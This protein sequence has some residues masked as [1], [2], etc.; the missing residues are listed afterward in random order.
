[1]KKIFIVALI[2]KIIISLFLKYLSYT[3]DTDPLQEEVILKYFTEKE[4]QDGVEYSRSGF[5]ISLFSQFLDYAMLILLVF[6][7]FSQ[8][9]EKKITDTLSSGYY[10]PTLVFL[11]VIYFFGF[12]LELPFGYYYEMILEKEFGFS[13][14]TFESWINLNIKNFFLGLFSMLFSGWGII[15]LL[16]TF[17]RSWTFLV[18]IVSFILSLF[19]TILYPI[20]ITPLYY[21][22]EP[23]TK[24]SLKMKINEL[25]SKENI[26]V[27]DVYM[28]M[29]SEYS[30]HTNAYFTGWGNQK[31]IFLYDTLIEKHTEEEIISILGHEIGHWKYNHQWKGMLLMTVLLFIGCV[32]VKWIFN[33]SKREGS[34]GLLEIHSPSTL[35]FLY[36]TFSLLNFLLT[37]LESTLSRMDESDADRVAIEMTGDVESAI[38]TEIKL[39]RDNKS[40]LNPHPLVVLFFYSHPKAID[41]IL[42]AESFR[43]VR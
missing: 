26:N 2:T 22:I 23:I 13:N 29:E 19:I 24:E 37:P 5:G 35:P 25:C 6:F 9:L 18:P 15:F 3:G 12:I 38:S 14:L 31:K 21:K 28:I 16:K 36:L 39:A 7:S 43:K 33:F 8:K 1:M 20:L 42:F 10:I 32:T 27:E 34:F 4:L 40:R 17:P 30:N 41:R 11:F